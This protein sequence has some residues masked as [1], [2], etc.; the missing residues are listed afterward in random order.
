MGI[1]FLVSN[2]PWEKYNSLAKPAALPGKSLDLKIWK[3]YNANC[4]V[5]AVPMASGIIGL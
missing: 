4:L 3:P 2:A 1:N 5:Q